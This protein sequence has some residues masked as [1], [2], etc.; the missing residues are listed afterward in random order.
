M[1]VLNNIGM[2]GDIT[3]ISEVS[4]AYEHVCSEAEFA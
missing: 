1:A 3:L 2:D 4:V